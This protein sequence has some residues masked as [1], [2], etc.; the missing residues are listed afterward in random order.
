MEE[1]ARGREGARGTR[2]GGGRGAQGR[3]RCQKACAPK[4]QQAF[5]LLG[6]EHAPDDGR[7]GR[8][9]RSVRL[10]RREIALVVETKNSDEEPLVKSRCG[11]TPES[12]ARVTG[13]GSGWYREAKRRKRERERERGR[14]SR[15]RRCT[16]ARAC[17]EFRTGGTGW[18]RLTADS[19]RNPYQELTK[20][21]VAREDARNT[22]DTR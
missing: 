15:E 18:W 6:S 8:R 10:S 4:Y 20:L 22:R 12:R 3:S 1:R 13:K 21:T 9:I 2:G 5:F 17:V 14:T 7:S 16:R 19:S 11:L